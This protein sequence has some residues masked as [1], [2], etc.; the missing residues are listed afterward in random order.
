MNVVLNCPGKHFFVYATLQEMFLSIVNWLLEILECVKQRTTK[1]CTYL[2][3]CKKHEHGSTKAWN[4][5]D[6]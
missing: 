4:A 3:L 1:R 5:D 2:I 6:F